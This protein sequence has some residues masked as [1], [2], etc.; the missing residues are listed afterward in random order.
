MT[1]YNALHKSKDHSTES[2]ILAMKVSEYLRIHKRSGFE[3]EV[4]MLNCLMSGRIRPIEVLKKHVL[5]FPQAV[6][7]H[8]L[9]SNRL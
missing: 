6:P 5:V 9:C 1:L 8:D 4:E 2:V 3:K 7:L